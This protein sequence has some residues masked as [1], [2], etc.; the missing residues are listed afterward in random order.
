[1]EL[2]GSKNSAHDRDIDSIL[3]QAFM[4]NL[5]KRIQKN[6]NANQEGYIVIISSKKEYFNLIDNNETMFFLEYK[7]LR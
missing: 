1:M 2:T 5:K 4:N 7:S 3:L 6:I